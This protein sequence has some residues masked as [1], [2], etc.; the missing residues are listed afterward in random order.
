MNP[1]IRHVA[2]LGD[3]FVDLYCPLESGSKLPFWGGDV[4]LR[5]GVSIKSG[6][7]ASNTAAHLAS[8]AS[9]NLARR[10]AKDSPGPV[11]SFHTIMG[12][13]TL[14]QVV[15]STHAKAGTRLHLA[16]L[17][18]QDAG[19]GQPTGTCVVISGDHDR[20]FMSTHGIMDYWRPAHICEQELHKASHLH[21]GGYFNFAKEVQI[22]LPEL[23]VKLRA[24]NPYLTVRIFSFFSRFVKYNQY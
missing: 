12:D 18:Q 1:E 6:G 4:L 17:T 7:S 5:G 9:N 21:I 23:V 22:S 10:D 2:V 3:T 24:S 15:T 20:A 14:G 8:L 13:D 11:V 19:F 16:Q